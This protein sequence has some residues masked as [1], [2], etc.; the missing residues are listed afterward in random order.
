LLLAVLDLRLAGK[1]PENHIRLVPALLTRYKEF[2]EVVAQ[3]QD[4]PNIHLPYFYMRSESFWELHTI[5]GEDGALGAVNSVTEARERIAYASLDGAVWDELKDPQ[6]IE[7][8]AQ[9]IMG[10]WFPEKLGDIRSAW[11]RSKEVSQYEIALESGAAEMAEGA[12][13]YVPARDA[14]FRRLVVEG[15]DYRCAASGW[16]FTLEGW[17]LVEAAH[18]VPFKESHDDRPE[19]GIALTPT[20]HR[21]MDKSVIA[22]GPDLKWHVSPVV[23]RRIPDNQK[24]VDLEG[25]SLILPSE[26]RFQ[27]DPEALERRLDQLLQA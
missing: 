23:D 11:V 2:F 21:L 15:Y 25:A 26:R 12:G 18:I 8:A 1:L 16:R 22:P 5:P 24:L 10:H 27:P 9:V 13:L 20:F 6:F 17:S 7:E 3:G 4:T 14:A 19:N